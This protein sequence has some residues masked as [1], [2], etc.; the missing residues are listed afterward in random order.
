M[1][2]TMKKYKEDLYKRYWDYQ[3]N[4]Y[5]IANDF[6]DQGFASNNRPPVFLKEK[7]SMNIIVNPQVSNEEMKKLLNYISP[8]KRHR[9]FQSMNSSQA[10]AQSV[11]GNLAVYDELNILS[12]LTDDN[13]SLLFNG[14]FLSPD[15]FSMEHEIQHLG[16]PRSTSLD[17][18]FSGK[19]RVV[20]ECKFTEEKFGT[21]SRPLLK[22]SDSNYLSDFCDGSYSRQ[23][24]RKTRCSLTEIGVKYWS[25]IPDLFKWRNDEE[26]YHCPINNNYQLVR[27]ILAACVRTNGNVSL[28]NGHVVMIYDE[29]NPSFRR[30][31]KGLASFIETGKALKDDSLLRKCSWQR[32]VNHLRFKG[33]LPWLT[34][35]IK[36]KYGI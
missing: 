13:G 16:E 9:W 19:Y 33:K 7:A 2:V 11:L 23:G 3:K 26:H 17:G 18:F 36:Q 5:P 35:E 29:R 32:I 10:L 22:P 1:S 12:D 15:H 4:K 6:F 20:I 27:N 14:E 24:N 31:G 34:Y 30:G 21:C 25:Y 8:S 28:T